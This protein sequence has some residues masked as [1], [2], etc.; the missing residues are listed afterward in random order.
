MKSEKDIPNCNGFCPTC[1][2]DNLT[3]LTKKELV[4]ISK[5][6]NFDEEIDD[7][8]AQHLNSSDPQN[9]DP[10]EVEYD[11]QCNECDAFIIVPL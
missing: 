6:E 4:R 9:I 2:S 5:E 1:G 10:G 8:L 11:C 7:R 3:P